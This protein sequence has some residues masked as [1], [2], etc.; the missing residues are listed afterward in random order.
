MAPPAGQ[1]PL[2]PAIVTN[3]DT[4][5]RVRKVVCILQNASYR[6]EVVPGA[7]NSLISFPAVKISRFNRERKTHTRVSGSDST[8]SSASRNSL[9]NC[10]SIAF[11]GSDRKETI[12]ISGETRDIVTFE[13]DDDDDDVEA[14]ILLILILLIL[15]LLL[16]FF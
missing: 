4:N 13:D 10:K 15:L 5:K 16:L 11:A 1:A 12:A 7:Y 8:R 9:Q 3:G 6:S 2:I 14:G